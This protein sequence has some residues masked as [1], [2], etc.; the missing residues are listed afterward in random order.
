MFEI[1]CILDLKSAQTV[2][3]TVAARGHTAD[4]LTRE[5]DAAREN[6][7]GLNSCKPMNGKRSYFQSH[8]S[9]N[10]VA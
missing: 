2:V 9:L 6:V 10:K 1:R 3:V 4:N 8:A 7:T 5:I